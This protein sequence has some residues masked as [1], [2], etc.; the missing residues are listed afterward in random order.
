MKLKKLR[1]SSAKK[2]TKIK[3]ANIA[4][5]YVSFEPC[6]ENTYSQIP[7]LKI[8]HKY[9]NKTYYI[10]ILSISGIDIFNYTDSDRESAYRNFASASL[11]LEIPHK[12]IF[13]DIRP[14]FHDQKEY[15]RYKS[16]KATHSF[17]KMMLEKRYNEFEMIEENHYDRL[18][19]LIAYS[20]DKHKLD[21]SIDMYLSKMTDVN[22]EVCSIPIMQRVLHKLMS[23]DT[24]QNKTYNHDL[25]AYIYPER[26]HFEQNSYK[27]NNLYATTLIVYDYPAYLLDLL[28]ASYVLQSN[29]I[30]VTLDSIKRDKNTITKEIS[31]SLDE[32]NGRG[33]IKQKVSNMIDTATEFEK[34]QALYSDISNG[35]E[36]V[37]GVTLRFIITSGDIESLSK[38]VDKIKHKLEDDGLHS[39]VP[40]NQMV[41]EYFSL[42]LPSNKIGNPFPLHDTYARQYPFYYQQHIDKTGMYFG[43]TATGGIVALNTFTKNIRRP[44]FDSLFT[45]VKGS[46]KTINLK[47]LLEDQVLLGNKVF[48]LDIEGEFCRLAQVYD[49]Q[50][51]RMTR[52]S[53]INPLQISKTIDADAENSENETGHIMTEMEARETNFQSEF[54]RINTFMHQ[55]HP[56]FSED[57]EIKFSELLNLVY[58]KKGINHHTDLTQLSATDF[59]TFSDVLAACETNYINAETQHDKEVCERLRSILRRLSKGGVYE[60]FDNYTNVD[61]YNTN[62]IVFDVRAISEMEENVYNAQMFNILSMM[63]SEVCRNVPYNRNIINPYDRRYVVC[64]IDEAHRFISESNPQCT[65]FIEKLTRRSRKYFS[66]LWFATQSILDFLP[67]GFNSTSDIAKHIKVIFQLVQYKVILKQDSAAIEDLHVAFPQFTMSELKSTPEFVP[68]E[69]LLA[70]DS[71]RMKIHCQRR[72]TDANL[73]YM[74]TSQ[75]A[76]DIIN[77]YFDDKFINNNNP[78]HLTQASYGQQ[79]IES[80]ETYDNFILIFTD[81]VLEKIEIPK[82]TSDVIDNIVR[83]NV[84]GLAKAL[85]D[86]AEMLGVNA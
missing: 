17:C 75:D 70:L 23:L 45:G 12:Y 82:G 84:I 19:Y 51:I 44:S 39:Y 66:A 4:S 28:F 61:I 53:I 78:N 63:W 3:A 8:K 59:P 31:F 47:A 48:A 13:T 20:E 7:S 58:M 11:A 55:I 54:S 42:I 1:Y 29:D 77:R 9:D 73:L 21:D 24:E 60:I 68:G 62:F 79:L 52:N 18:A 41:N 10:S 80:K 65:L 74:G 50:V 67:N 57:E 5:N 32:L 40:I 56:G 33:G 69:M 26:V 35:N 49:G 25:N 34:V 83:E 2:Q 38:K 16:G 81:Y 36:Q 71:G 37:F 14:D 72:V 64:L 86:K 76:S 43:R 30:T 15:I 46:G 27:V 22:I 85:M 6:E